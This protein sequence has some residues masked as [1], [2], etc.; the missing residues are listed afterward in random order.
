MLRPGPQTCRAKGAQ[1][2]LGPHPRPTRPST[3]V[4]QQQLV[5][6]VVH[7]DVGALQCDVGV[8]APRGRG[9]TRPRAV[10]TSRSIV[11]L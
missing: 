9:L 1:V 10:V 11:F 4:L 3:L 2:D 6:N 5:V 8:K 7:Q